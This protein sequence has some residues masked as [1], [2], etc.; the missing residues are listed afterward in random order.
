MPPA[1]APIL[2]I[3]IELTRLDLAK[4]TVRLS[5]R[6]STWLLCG[7]IGALLAYATQSS[8]QSSGHAYPLPVS[9][10][11]GLFLFCGFMLLIITTNVLTLQLRIGKRKGI[12][13]MHHYAIHE[14]GLIE[15]TEV[16]ESLA[17][18]GSFYRIIKSPRRL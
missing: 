7:G 17:K 3:D 13:G 15:S 6:L 1:D 16:N 10:I 14:S 8:A 5:L 4:A 11:L 9:I 18:W 12:L 2:S